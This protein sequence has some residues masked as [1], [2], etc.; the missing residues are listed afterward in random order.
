MKKLP[1]MFI[2]S[3]LMGGLVYPQTKTDATTGGLSTFWQASLTAETNKD[4]DMAL[5]QLLS[6]QHTGGDPFLANLRAG[7]LYYLKQDFKNAI[8]CYNE[9]ERLQPSSINPLLGLLNISQAEGDPGEIGKAVDQVLHADPLNYRA[10]MAGAGQQFTAKSYSQALAGYRLVLAYYPDDLEARSGEGWCFYCLGDHDKAAA[11][12]QFL[13]S[14][15][16]S[17]PWAQQGLD[18]CLNKVAR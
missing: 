5:N 3:A 14:V 16:A 6:Y 4:Y 12:F 10:Q 11:D 2:F 13:L 1:A 18:L 15:N 9:A 8:K 17:Y 7:W